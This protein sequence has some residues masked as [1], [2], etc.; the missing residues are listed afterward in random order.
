MYVLLQICNI[1][2]I[3]GVSANYLSYIIWKAVRMLKIA[4]LNVI[5]VVADGASTN[6]RFLECIRLTSTRRVKLLIKHLI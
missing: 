6:R 4:G 5:A 3:T 1:H 2:N